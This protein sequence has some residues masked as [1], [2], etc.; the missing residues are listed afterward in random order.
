MD[1]IKVKKCVICGKKFEGYGNN[2]WPL[3]NKGY[4]CNECNNK[5]IAQRLLDF[6]NKSKEED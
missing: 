5:V 4:C 1:R 3:S 6:E 2:P